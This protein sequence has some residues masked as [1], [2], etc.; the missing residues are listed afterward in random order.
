MGCDIHAHFE[1]KVNDKWLHWNQPNIKRNYDLFAK[2]A[3]VR[4]EGEIK[5]ITEPRGLP[6]DITETTRLHFK[7]WI[8]DGH[9]HSW[10]N[11]FEVALIIE[12]HEQQFEEWGMPT[13][14][15]HD[16]WGYLFGNGYASFHR[17]REEYP[18]EIQDFRLVFW[19]DN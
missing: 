5:P 19:F 13:Y 11:S 9:S 3:N 7:H 17:Y 10:L 12:F 14:K 15:V 2:M 4:N 1:I 18:V 6:D 8:P 16:Q